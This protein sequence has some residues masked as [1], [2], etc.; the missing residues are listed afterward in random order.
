[1]EYEFAVFIGRFQPLHIGHQH[2]IDEALRKADRLILLV[3]S[4]DSARSI[5]NPF[6]FEERKNQFTQVYRH[7]L[8]SGRIHIRPIPDRAYND[9]AWIA[10]AQRIV[11]ETVL[12]LG[13]PSTPGSTLHGLRDFKVALAGYKKDGTSYYLKMFPDWGSI[14]VAAQHGT[15][16][17][18]DIRNDYF[19]RS[20]LLPHDNCHPAVVEWLKEFR[21][22][23]AFAHLVQEREYVDRY[24]QSWASAPYPPVFVTVDAVVVQSGHVLLIRRGEQPGKG[25]LALPGGFINQHERL[26]DAVVREL[27]EETMITDV[28]PAR[29]EKRGKVRDSIPRGVLASYIDDAA[30]RVFDDPHRSVRGRVITHAFLFR[31]PDRRVLFQVR[32]GD[33]AAAAAWH[34]LGELNPAEFFEDHFSI[35]DKMIGL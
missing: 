29:S 9:D 23:P 15:F 13:N 24:R 16:N 20:P 22:T 8:A 35:L 28:D 26:Q 25:L 34:K 33:D 30:T 27:R 11:N 21:L 32:G 6:T 14:D 7:E 1:M 10:E 2:V 17:S 31:C 18:S 12:D 4:S 5:R 19:R 3:G